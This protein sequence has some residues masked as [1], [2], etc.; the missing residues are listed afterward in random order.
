MPMPVDRLRHRH[1]PSLTIDVTAALWRWLGRLPVVQRANGR[2][3]G[4]QSTYRYS[5]TFHHRT[6]TYHTGEHWEEISAGR[7]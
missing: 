5:C 1:F 3:V 2:A 4:E 6:G 7:G